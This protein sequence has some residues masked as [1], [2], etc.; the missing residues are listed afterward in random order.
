MICEMMS[1]MVLKK[2]KIVGT[3]PDVEERIKQKGLK[4]LETV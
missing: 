3:L 4:R 2:M 1:T